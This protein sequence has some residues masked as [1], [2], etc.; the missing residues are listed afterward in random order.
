MFAH[1]TLLPKDADNY[2]LR[3]WHDTPDDP[4]GPIDAATGQPIKRYAADCVVSVKDGVATVSSVMEAPIGCW[5]AVRRALAAKGI[6]LAAG[7]R[8]DEEGK[9]RPVTV[10]IT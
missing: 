8:W 10:P 1:L 5:W 4:L 7:E 3:V 6:K 9:K 2:E